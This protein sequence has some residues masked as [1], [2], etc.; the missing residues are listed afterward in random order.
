MIQLLE[1]KT[2]VRIIIFTL[3][4]TILA[5]LVPSNI[6][7]AN[8]ETKEAQTI[9]VNDSFNKT[10]GDSAFDLQAIASGTLTYESNNRQVAT[11][12]DAGIVTITGVGTATITIRAAETDTYASA[13]KLVRVTVEKGTQTITG[14]SSIQKYFRYVV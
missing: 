5:W 14:A 3:L 12:S 11:V 2:G 4:L 6:G 7:Q 13:E 1:K 8:A 9:T 10:Y